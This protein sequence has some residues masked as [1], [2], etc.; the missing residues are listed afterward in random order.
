MNG[1]RKNMQTKI[2]LILLFVT[3][4]AFGKTVTI[5]GFMRDASS[6]EALIGANIYISMLETGTSTN[7]Y[8]FYSISIPFSDSIGVIYSYIGFEPQIKKLY[9]K[10]N[11]KLD[12]SLIPNTIAM[13]EVVV[14]GHKQNENVEIK[15]MSIVDVPVRTINKLPAILGESDILKVVQLLPGIQSGSEGTTGYFVRGGNADQNL[16]LLDEATVYN[17]NHLFGLM[18]TFN[19]RAIN[20]VT[21]IKGGFPAQYGGRLSSN[22]NITMKEGNNKDYHMN[23]GLGLINSKLTVEGPIIKN[24]ASFII[25]A[26]RTYMDL[27]LKPFPKMLSTNYSFYDI[28]ARVNFKLSDKDR[29]FLSYFNGQD[30][31]AYV[32][33][34]SLNYD[35]MFGNSTA[36]FRWNHILNEKLFVNTSLIYN[37]FL[38][39]L[40]TIQSSFF[41]EFYS[42]IEDYN[43]KIDFE[44]F[45]GPRN[46][47]KF[48]LNYIHHTFTPTG[49]SG[50]TPKDS[51][52]KVINPG[53]I[54]TKIA[55]ETALYI[56]DEINLTNRLGLNIGLRLPGFQTGNTSYFHIEPRSTFK[57]TLTENSSVKAAYTVMNQFV[58]LVPSATASIP[59][60]IWLPSSK[61]VKPQQSKQVALGYFL[62][63][64]DN[65]YEASVETY[66]KTMDRQVAF[67]EGTQLIEQTNIDSQLVFGKGWS[68]GVEFFLKKKAGRFSGW[69]SYTLSWSNQ[70]FPDL[71]FG[72]V[73]PF[74][75]DRRH[76]LSLVGVYELNKNWTLSSN[77]VF[78]SGNTM[79]LPGGRVSVYEGGDLYNG[80]F[81]VYVGKNNYRLNPYHR[82]DI[83]AT[84]KHKGHLFHQSY[85]G[86]LVMSVYNAY[87]RMNPYFVYVDFDPTSQK[88]FAKQVSLLP[89][90]PSISY[91]FN[92]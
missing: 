89:I 76:N 8:G 52:L 85:N 38:M 71:N 36:T 10:D 91:N 84:Y 74:K 18:S 28:N 15:Q 4:T 14:S 24:K 35:F 9:I 26:R 62:N 60:D 49:T 47:V 27:L 90:I 55:S 83:A 44:Y 72:K 2:G 21:L 86:E 29:M 80:V 81:D 37:G 66:Y 3:L 56:N 79:T 53:I 88:A 58:H 63:L 77:F 39:D 75:Y 33:V 68:Y 1:E 73:F 40:K 13:N 30:R 43:G 87:S 25:S 78:T 20:N 65:S 17:P 54:Q 19:S 22:M 23:I 16:V 5:S 6:G 59:T 50:K 69:A 48:G 41:A 12:I 46:T 92:F 64:R 61:I 42:K 31:A 82:L 32:A 11:L 45:L 57:Y 34:N 51:T 7:S 67:K 70:Q